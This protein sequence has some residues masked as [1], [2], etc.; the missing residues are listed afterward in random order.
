[1]RYFSILLIGCIATTVLA[2]E[3]TRLIQLEKQL[4]RVIQESQ[5]AYQQFQMIQELHRNESQKIPSLV[6]SHP[7]SQSISIPSQEELNRLIQEKDERIK[8]YSSDLIRLYSRYQ[9]LENE[10]ESIYEQIRMLEQSATAEE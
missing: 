6:P 7:T 1:M 5:A 9:E 4:S 10:R 3:D 8:K 2:A